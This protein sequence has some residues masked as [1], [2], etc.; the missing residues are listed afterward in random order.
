MKVGGEVENMSETQKVDE[1]K[2]YGSTFQLSS[3]TELEF[4]RQHYQVWK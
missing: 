3:E 4:H 2:R 1:E